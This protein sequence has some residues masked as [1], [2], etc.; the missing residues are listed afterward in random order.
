I[1]PKASKEGQLYEGNESSEKPGGGI[2]IEKAKMVL[3]AEDAFDR[4][5]ERARIKEVHKEKK[6]KEKELK[7]KRRKEQEGEAGE[8][9]DSEEEDEDVED[10][11]EEDGKEPNLDWSAVRPRRKMR[12]M[13]SSEDEDGEDVIT[14]KRK[15]H[16]IGNN[17]SEDDGHDLLPLLGRGSSKVVTK[18]AAVKKALKKNIQLNQKVK[19]DD[20]G[21]AHEDDPAIQPKASKEG[22]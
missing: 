22:Q 6:R 17:D 20:D 15:D 8:D 10:E 4:K 7:N 1:Q 3:K 19:F 5:T 9:Q 11:E 14:M 21:G 12:L 2:D 13:D 18:A 16:A